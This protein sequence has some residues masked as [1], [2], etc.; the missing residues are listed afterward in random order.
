[1]RVVT[2]VTETQQSGDI[3]PIYRFLRQSHMYAD[4]DIYI[5]FFQLFYTLECFNRIGFRH[6]DL[7]L[8]N[9][10][11]LENPPEIRDNLRLFRYKDMRGKQKVIKIPYG[12]WDIRIFDLDR[13]QKSTAPSSND[14]SFLLKNTISSKKHS[15]LFTPKNSTKPLSNKNVKP[16]F[17]KEYVLNVS[18]K[19]SN[20]R[21]RLISRMPCSMHVVC[22]RPA[23]ARE[24]RISQKICSSSVAK[25]Q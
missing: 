20:K 12:R 17:K 13:A 23:C 25:S 19:I 5:V 8:G 9:I 15:S 7:H 21:T 6:N 24:H 16:V 3:M 10:L 1:M 22:S 4:L 14:Y 11:V 2:L 18:D